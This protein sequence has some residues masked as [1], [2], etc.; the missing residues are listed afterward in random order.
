MSNRILECALRSRTT[1]KF[2]W[3]ENPQESVSTSLK[4]TTAFLEMRW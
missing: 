3:E 2:L 1:T 4:V